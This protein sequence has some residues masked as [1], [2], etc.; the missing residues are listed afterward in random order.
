MYHPTWTGPLVRT[1]SFVV[2][3]MC[4]DTEHDLAEA[5]RAL[6]QRHFPPRATALFDDVELVNHEAA[7]GPIRAALASGN[8]LDEVELGNRL[9][10][11]LRAQ[12]RRV[13]DL[14]RSEP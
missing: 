12:Y 9:I 4:V 7:T 14:A 6:A 3:V 1:L 5:Y 2:R 10:V 8:P 11:A 13:V